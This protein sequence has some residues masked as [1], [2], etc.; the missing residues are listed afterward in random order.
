MNGMGF[1]PYVI[2]KCHLSSG[3][4]LDEDLSETEVE[5]RRFQGEGRAAGVN[6]YLSVWARNRKCLPRVGCLG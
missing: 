2:V 1:L 3:E 5:V 6:E 4:F